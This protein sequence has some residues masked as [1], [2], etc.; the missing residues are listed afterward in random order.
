MSDKLYY[1]RVTVLA[2][3]LLG[4]V[5]SVKAEYID[6]SQGGQMKSDWVM[7]QDKGETFACA[8]VSFKNKNYVVLHDQ[9]GERR[10]YVIEGEELILLWD[11][12][13]I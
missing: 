13:G 7:C 10:I 11:R 4:V 3:I 6:L 9:K 12:E 8:V 1:L 5:T 2:I